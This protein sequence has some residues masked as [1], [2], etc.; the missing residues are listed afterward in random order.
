MV[1]RKKTAGLVKIARPLEWI[2]TVGNMLLGALIAAQVPSNFDWQLFFIAAVA[3]GPLLWGGLYTL[4]DWVD[5]RKDAIHHVKR[6]RP[7]PSGL[8]SPNLAL[9]FAIALIVA[10]F[11]IAFYFVKNDLF[12]ICL[13]VM[14][15]NQLLY[16]L[17]PIQL[18]VRPLVDII[19]GSMINP[20]FRFLAGW[21]L[22]A[23]NWNAPLWMLLVVMGFEFGYILYR[24]GS[25]K[26]EQQLGYKSSAVVFSEK[27]LKLLAYGGIFVGAAS[28]VLAAL[29]KIF[30]INLLYFFIIFIA[31]IFPSYHKTLLDPQSMDMKKMHTQTYVHY[32]LF[33]TGFALIWLYL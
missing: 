24:L 10:A 11:V 5:W 14:L 30:S 31:L 12:T 15:A 18:K 8:I 4:N 7:I 20:A 25:K 28:F 3:A 32:I 6:K 22:F 2:K 16:T 1:I 23:Q 26:H 33:V 19:S 9:L 27:I 29:Q 21:V 13:A 17:P